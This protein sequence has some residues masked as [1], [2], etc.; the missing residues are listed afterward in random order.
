MVGDA[1]IQPYAILILFNALAYL[2][3]SLD[4]TGL[5]AMVAYKVAQSAGSSGKRLFFYFFALASAMTIFTSNDIVTLT[6]T[7][8]VFYCSAATKTSPFPYLF[9]QFYA[10]NIC[11]IVLIIGNPT[12]VIV[13]EAFHLTV[14]K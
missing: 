1:D 10:A 4:H 11:S 7:P 6:L 2:C 9:A 8:V 3:I 14:R 12:N 5:L 13:G